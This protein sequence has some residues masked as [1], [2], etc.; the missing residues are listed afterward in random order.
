[1][2]L[3]IVICIE[4]YL[5]LLRKRGAFGKGTASIFRGHN[6][7]KWKLVPRAHRPDGGPVRQAGSAEKS[8]VERIEREQL[9]EFRKRALPHI[10]TA[11]SDDWNWLAL[12]QHHGMETRLL[13]WTTNPL[14]ALFF[15]IEK[16]CEV[17]GTIWCCPELPPQATEVDPFS[18]ET[19]SLYLPPSVSPRIPAQGSVFT[20]H[21]FGADEPSAFKLVTAAGG[22]ERDLRRE[23][24]Q[25]NISRSTLFP[26]L[27]GVAA[28]INLGGY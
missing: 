7:D 8:P 23:L 19:V 15:A 14:V 4:N 25:L 20:A 3:D 16:D 28:G 2:S 1:M 13:D 22:I 6:S 10:T 27:D 24:L 5:E 12:A 26:D 9:D 11:P 21:P 18:I 17:G